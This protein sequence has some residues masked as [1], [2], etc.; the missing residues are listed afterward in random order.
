MCRHHCFEKNAG[1][2][3]VFQIVEMKGKQ[4]DLMRVVYL[5]YI[6][7]DIIGTLKENRRSF[8]DV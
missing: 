1:R 7:C 2:R 6:L 8:R 4:L 5:F 3:I